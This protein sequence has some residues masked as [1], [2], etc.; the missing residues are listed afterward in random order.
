MDSL[1][2]VEARRW[3]LDQGARLDQ[4]GF[5]EPASKTGSFIIPAD[6]GKRVA[7]VAGHLKPLRVATNTL[8]WFDDWSVWP[9]GQRMHIFERFLASYGEPRALIERPAFLFSQT[10]YEDVASFVTIGVLF[11]WDVHVVSNGCG[12]LLFYSHNESGWV[13]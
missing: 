13:G 9:S 1:T 4:K 6:A 10:E 2:S 7:L 3:C 8:V 11:L 12:H 5:P